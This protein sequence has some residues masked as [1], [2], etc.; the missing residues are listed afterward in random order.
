M[1]SKNQL[2]RRA[3]R[4]CMS[5]ALAVM[6]IAGVTADATHNEQESTAV[7]R[8][9]DLTPMRNN[10]MHGV[11]RFIR[12]AAPLLRKAAVASHVD[13]DGQIGMPAE[14]KDL[15]GGVVMFYTMSD[16][17]KDEVVCRELLAIVT[18]ASNTGQFDS[19]D[20]FREEIN[21]VGEAGN[22][23]RWWA[24]SHFYTIGLLLALDD[25]Q[26]E[27]WM[28]LANLLNAEPHFDLDA[29]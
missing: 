3:A 26:L 12:N 27:P 20:L 18:Q 24:E 16:D 9:I 11:A 4:K 7:D 29:W 21:K 22:T 28:T 8:I 2:S 15:P 1:F 13:D 14:R 23:G 10:A 17:E 19:I 5:C 25:P 6:A